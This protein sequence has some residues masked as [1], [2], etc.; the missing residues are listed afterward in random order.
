MN[1]E[2]VKR[3]VADLHDKTEY[4]IHIRNVKEALKHGLVLKRIIQ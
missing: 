3:L 4:D 1:I 2:K